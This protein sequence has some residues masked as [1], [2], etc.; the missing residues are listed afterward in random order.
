MRISRKGRRIM[1]KDFQGAVTG[2]AQFKDHF[3]QHE[4]I[5]QYNIHLLEPFSIYIY[6]DI[7]ISIYISMG[8]THS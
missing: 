6:I 7:Y 2:P 5:Q 1:R 4:S 8:Q 3:D